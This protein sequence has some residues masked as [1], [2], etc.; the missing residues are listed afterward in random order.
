[1]AFYDSLALAVTEAISSWDDVSMTSILQD[2]ASLYGR[3]YPDEYDALS[4]V[5]Y[6]RRSIHVAEVD[7]SLRK[8]MMFKPHGSSVWDLMI[9]AVNHPEMYESR[10][11]D[12]EELM[13][14]LQVR[15]IR[16]YPPHVISLLVKQDL[17]MG[18]I[19]MLRALNSCLL[20]LRSYPIW[21][22]HEL[23]NNL[24]DFMIRTMIPSIHKR[25][26][27]YELHKLTQCMDS[28][29]KPCVNSLLFTLPV[30]ESA[31]VYSKHYRSKPDI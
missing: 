13:R 8:L 19:G 2:H 6:I 30:S 25:R 26:L 14:S 28:D 12:P 17:E 4:L 15:D 22:L 10:R 9:F 20:R 11:Y 21:Y 29:L 5:E 27:G 1:M 24:C 31:T 3:Y 16:K 7:A 18:S 23:R